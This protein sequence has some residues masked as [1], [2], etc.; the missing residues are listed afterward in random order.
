MQLLLCS[1]FTFSYT[2]QH[3]IIYM[4]TIERRKL[5][6]VQRSTNCWLSM[7]SSSSWRSLSYALYFSLQSQRVSCWSIWFHPILLV[8]T[9]KTPVSPNQNY[10]SARVFSAYQTI[11]WRFICITLRKFLRNLS[12][13]GVTYLLF[14]G[15]SKDCFLCILRLTFLRTGKT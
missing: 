12:L 5:H 15:Q 11:V 9:G 13:S 6:F 4:L 14:N 3:I 1:Y 10:Y 7:Y 8:L 2:N